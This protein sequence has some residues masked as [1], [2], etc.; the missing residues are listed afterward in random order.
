MNAKEPTFITC[1]QNTQ[2]LR[3]PIQKLHHPTTTG[4]NGKQICP[5]QAPGS[6]A[7]E[8]GPLV[9]GHAAQGSALN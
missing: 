5:I 8:Q 2:K 9:M 7:C 1:M 4:H 6:M 3:F